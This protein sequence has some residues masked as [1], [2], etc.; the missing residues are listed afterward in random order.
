VVAARVQ[1][2]RGGDDQ[3]PGLPVDGQAPVELGEA[4]VVT[5]RQA[6]ADSGN[7]GRDG[8]V[9]RG[10]G[11]RL[12][13]GDPSGDLHV[14][15][16]DLAVAGGQL[17]AW[18]EDQGRVVGA[19]RVGAG[20]VE[21][22]GVDP[23]AQFAGGAGEELGEFT[24]G[25]L[26]LGG[27]VARAEVVDVFRQH[28]QL[29]SGGSRPLEEAAGHLEVVVSIGLRIHLTHRDAHACSLRADPSWTNRQK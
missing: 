25:P 26:G 7:V 4:Q 18:V 22:A 17:A 16:M 14:V 8:L 21:G 13:I 10:H 3:D 5:D 12:L 27:G 24:V 15:Q 28:G 9:A 2:E 11:S 20:L 1:H 29:G 6:G 19:A 23:D